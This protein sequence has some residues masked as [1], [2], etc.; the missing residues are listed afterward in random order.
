METLKNITFKIL[1]YSIY[2]IFLLSCNADN[3]E[4][5]FK[6]NGIITLNEECLDIP[7]DTFG[8]KAGNYDKYFI[9][10]KGD[11]KALSLDDLVTGY[12]SLQVRIWLGHSLANKKHV[13][14][15]KSRKGNWYA[16][17]IEYKPEIGEITKQVNES[18]KVFR[19]I[20]P[21]SGWKEFKSTFNNLKIASLPHSGNLTG[22]SG[23][24]GTDGIDYC[25]EI[26]TQEN[27]RFFYYCNPRV[28]VEEFWQAQSVLDF[29]QYL[30]R[31]FDFEFIE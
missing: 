3:P 16:E 7:V 18:K 31:E 28:N 25:F 27:Y 17:L 4:V 22:Y 12:D 30:K 2:L 14:V 13:L 10:R 9:E 8:R 26:S 19:N 20:S 1:Y 15:I 24:G 6:Q 5:Y 11:A 21:K 29:C 23:C